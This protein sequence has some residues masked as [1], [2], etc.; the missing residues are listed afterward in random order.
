[1][2]YLWIKALWIG[3]HLTIDVQVSDIQMNCSVSTEIRN[4]RDN[5]S[6]IGHKAI[7]SVQ[8]DSLN[9]PLIR[10][11]KLR[12]AH[13]QRMPGTFPSPP[14][15]SDP[16]MHRGMCVTHVPWCM[17]G[18]L[19]SGFLWSRWRGTRLRHFRRMRNPQCYVSG[20]GPMEE[21]WLLHSALVSLYF[22]WIVFSSCSTILAMRLLRAAPFIGT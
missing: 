6:R 7:W 15:V 11:V 12:A 17:P 13:A 20:K 3:R 18:S 21:H 14:Q 16:D 19:S 2:H 5:S 10:Y 8:L 4:Y 9:G 22:D 1:M